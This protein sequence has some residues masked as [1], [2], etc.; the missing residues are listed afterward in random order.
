MD[1]LKI[2]KIVQRGLM[3]PLAASLSEH[4]Y[5]H[6]IQYQNQEIDIGITCVYSSMSLYHMWRFPQ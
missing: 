6:I 2:A 4:I 3:Y 1:T 5:I